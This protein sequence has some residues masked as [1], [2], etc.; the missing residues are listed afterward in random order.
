M[1]PIQKAT[2]V[3]VL[4]VVIYLAVVVATTPALEPYAAISAAFQLNSI[5][6]I[7]M[8]IGIGLQVFLSEKSKLL[9]CKLDVKRKAFGGNSGSTAA[10]SFFSFFSLVPLGC[11][12][13]W[14]YAL[15]LLPSVVGTGVS[16]VL[17]EYS[18]VLAYV[19]LVIIFG[20]AGLT[21]VKLK[22]EQKLQNSFN[23]N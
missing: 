21:A 2:I 5:V 4:T 22:K 14:L 6:I 16:A 17:I 23:L 20:F 11:C 19:G 15:S 3:G 1:R 18:Q 13:W 7:G 12:G 10:T 9:G 8:G